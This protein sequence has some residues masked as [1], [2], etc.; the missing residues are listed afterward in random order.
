MSLY[1]AV[2]KI[3]LDGKLNSEA[4]PST[5]FLL[6]YNS[7]FTI[8]QPLGPGY[9]EIIVNELPNWDWPWSD[10][11]SAANWGS[12][13]GYFFKCFFFAV[14]HC[15]CKHVLR[16]ESMIKCSVDEWI[17]PVKHCM[18]KWWPRY[19]LTRNVLILKFEKFCN[20]PLQ[21][22]CITMSVTW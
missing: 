5:V 12:L 16:K 22:A 20:L 15:T 14:I 19:Q 9:H 8:L 3:K 6:Y 21:L 11:T 7:I 4:C 1:V 13:K 10:G 17:S 18:Q 2:K